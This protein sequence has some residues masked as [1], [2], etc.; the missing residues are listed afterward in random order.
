MSD[1]IKFIF[2]VTADHGTFDE[3]ADSRTMELCRRF[4]DKRLDPDAVLPAPAVLRFVHFHCLSNKINVFDFPLSKTAKSLPPPK[5]NG[6]W[7]ALA[8]FVAS[9]DPRFSPALFVDSSGPFTILNIYHSIR[10]APARSVLELSIFSHGF[11][12]GPLIRASEGSDDNPPSDIE[13]RLDDPNG[14]ARTDFLNNMGEKPGVGTPQDKFPKTGGKDA[15]KEFTAAFDSQASF[16]IFGCNGQDPMREPLPDNTRIGNLKS[17]AGQVIHQAYVV[18]TQAKDKKEKNDAAKLGKVLATGKVPDPD[19]LEVPIDMGFEFDD[20]RRDIDL[21]QPRP[22]YHIFDA[23]DRAEDKEKRKEAHYRL[24]H[25]PT[26]FFPAPTSPQL[27]FT[28]KWSRVLGFVA[29]RTQK[30]YAFQAA[31]ALAPLGITVLGGPVGTKSRVFDGDQMKVCTH[32]LDDPE[33]PCPR[34][35]HFHEVF[36]RTSPSAKSERRYFV[37][38]KATVEKINDLAKTV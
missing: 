13:R 21:A 27:K 9:G 10:G 20:E 36:M 1:P 16:L 5:M 7:T 14:R 24:D 19:A 32:G 38:D 8:N 2:I 22:K 28:R 33:D 15:L 34:I 25:E 26:G 29:R 6:R 4:Y 30:T 12:E 23:N 3:P 35:V 17:S 18:P 31:S 37:F 11:A